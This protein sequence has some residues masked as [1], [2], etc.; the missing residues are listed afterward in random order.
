MSEPLKSV[1]VRL[2]PEVHARLET[3]AQLDDKGIAEMCEALLSRDVMGSFHAV[4]V[5]ADK[6]A[7]LGLS[8]KKRD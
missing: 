5:A 7:R 3:M 6:Y 4:T 8:G 2:P 1:H